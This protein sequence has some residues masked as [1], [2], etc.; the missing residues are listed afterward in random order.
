MYRSEQ[1]MRI[2]RIRNS[3][4]RS[5][6]L[7]LVGLIALAALGAGAMSAFGDNV[8]SDS[9]PN[10]VNVTPERTVSV[11]QGDGANAGFF[12]RLNDGGGDVAG[13]NADATHP[14]SLKVSSSNTSVVTLDNA[15]PDGTKTVQVTSCDL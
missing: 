8:L 2:P 1:S 3:R 10:T 11:H 13:C 9:T 14:V 7:T 12:L 15:A 6:R 5:I 4:R